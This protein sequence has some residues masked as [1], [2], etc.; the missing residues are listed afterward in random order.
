VRKCGVWPRIVR[1]TL[2]KV[3]HFSHVYA[4]CWLFERHAEKIAACR[5]YG[6]A[7]EKAG[8]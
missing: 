7:R 4:M 8:V 3:Q 2:S 1:D 5:A 6:C